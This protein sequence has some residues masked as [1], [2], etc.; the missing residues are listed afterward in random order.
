[1]AWEYSQQ[2]SGRASFEFFDHSFKWL[3]SGYMG[4]MTSVARAP[5]PSGQP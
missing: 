5:M 3:I 1:M 4:A 2:M